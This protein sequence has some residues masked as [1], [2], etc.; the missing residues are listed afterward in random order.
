MRLT[1]LALPVL[2]LASSVASAHP[3]FNKAISAQVEGV[4]MTIKYNTTPAN[5]MRADQAAK[6]VFVTPRGPRLTLATDL[7]AADKV[8]LAA[9]EYTIGVIKNDTD[10]TL[11]LYPGTIARGAT[12]DATKV[13]KMDSMF[14]TG[15]GDADH[16]LID[17]TPGHGKF[18]GKAV[19]TIH[20]GKLFLSGRLN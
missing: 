15:R 20:F 12:P 1:R 11:A 9:G 7:K 10:W 4:D 13:I 5:E 2:L 17:V 16:M 8:L 18:E 3:H 19:L 6:G 14:E